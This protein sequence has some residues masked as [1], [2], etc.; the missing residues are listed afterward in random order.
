MN[1]TETVLR[2]FTMIIEPGAFL[3]DTLPFRESF[4]LNYG[5]SSDAETA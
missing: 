4:Y 5:A 1:N 3:V 2:N